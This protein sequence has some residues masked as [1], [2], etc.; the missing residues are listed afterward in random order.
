MQWPSNNVGLK[1]LNATVRTLRAEPI[2]YARRA[3]TVRTTLLVFGKHYLHREA[4]V[5]LEVCD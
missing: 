2:P 4:S 3:P 1:N 5:A